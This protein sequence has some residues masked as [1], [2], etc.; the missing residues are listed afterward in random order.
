[1]QNLEDEPVIWKI[2][3]SSKT[4][5][6]ESGKMELVRWQGR[7]VV[8]IT[9]WKVFI[10]RG[11]V[12]WVGIPPPSLGKGKH[13]EDPVTLTIRSLIAQIHPPSFTIP[14]PSKGR[15]CLL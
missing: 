2:H 10:K 11:N 4:L 15:C 9:S 3:K 8:I 14:V 13:V 6:S 7:T 1:M 5:F 12:G